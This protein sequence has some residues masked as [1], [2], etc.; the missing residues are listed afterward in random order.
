MKSPSSLSIWLAG[1]ALTCSLV[2]LAAASPDA[3]QTAAHA[4]VDFDR[5][6]RLI[7][8]ESCFAC[9]GFDEKKRQADLRL[10]IA[11]GAFKKLGTGH[12]A[13]VAGKPDAG[14]LIKRV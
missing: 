14:E 11:D 8:S 1:V 2:G 5:D 7:L 3:P 4:P 12:F 9:H 10:D 6:V 13:V